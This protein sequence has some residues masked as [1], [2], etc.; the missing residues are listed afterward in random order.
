MTNL[1][2]KYI[3]AFHNFFGKS[4]HA[5]YTTCTR[6]GDGYTITNQSP[7]ENKSITGI[8]SKC[9]QSIKISETNYDTSC[10]FQLRNMS[11]AEL[12]YLFRDNNYN[13]D[14]VKKMI[15]DLFEI[16]QNFKFFTE[17]TPIKNFELKDSYNKQI[18]Y[19]SESIQT[20]TKIT[21]SSIVANKNIQG[22]P[23]KKTS[24]FHL[25]F[26]L[27]EE[28]EI[29]PILTLIISYSTTKY[30]RF[31]INLHPSKRD[32]LISSISN[33]L[34]E[35]EGLLIK[36]LDFVLN[37]TLKIKKDELQT[38]TLEEKKNYLSVVDMV[39]F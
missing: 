29:H 5:E 11:D 26:Y 22:K 14:L 10:R 37:K 27:S 23:T 6:S 33:M 19:R 28:N 18:T 39:K 20:A 1:E 21:L 9:S 13:Y 32:E 17:M 36:Q 16:G 12:E 7:V 8:F 24:F 3:D 4:V 31:D 30:V 2:N 35:F 25:G 15:D 38:L 34:N